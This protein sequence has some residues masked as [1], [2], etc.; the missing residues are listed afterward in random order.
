MAGVL[1][2][3]RRAIGLYAGVLDRCVPQGSVRRTGPRPGEGSRGRFAGP[4]EN[5]GKGV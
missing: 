1:H 2:R 3:R 4:G 5:D